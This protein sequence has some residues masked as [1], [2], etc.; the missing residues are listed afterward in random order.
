MG[1]SSTFRRWRS[2]DRRYRLLVAEA[3]AGL[4]LSAVAIRLLPFR[5]AVRLG[6]RPLGRQAALD[7]A[8][9]VRAV[10]GATNHLPLR[11]A[12]F[13]RGLALQRMLR[14]RGIDAR[15]H[16]GVGTQPGGALKAHVWVSV[17]D[18]ILIG[19]A[20]AP[21]YRPLAVYP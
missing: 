2:H 4:L 16:Y 20:E 5:R 8:A 19:G 3:A 9:A 7:P 15:L 12:C 6:A 11:L 10:D 13:P 17:G 21:A 14:R 18:A 1:L